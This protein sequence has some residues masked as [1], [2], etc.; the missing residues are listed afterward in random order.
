LSIYSSPK[1]IQWE[2]AKISMGFFVVDGN[3]FSNCFVVALV[4]F[5][6]PSF[7]FLRLSYRAA[8]FDSKVVICPA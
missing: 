1:K 5:H 2:A 3:G 7:I 6:P 8:N 4:D